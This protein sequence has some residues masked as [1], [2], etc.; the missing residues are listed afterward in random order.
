M[1]PVEVCVRGCGKSQG[2]VCH[3]Y[4]SCM[5]YLVFMYSNTEQSSLSDGVYTLCAVYLCT[6]CL[7]NSRLHNSADKADV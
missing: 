2:T 3:V 6:M 4:T 1:C 7:C 5:Y